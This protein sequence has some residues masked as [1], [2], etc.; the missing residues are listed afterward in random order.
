MSCRLLRRSAPLLVLAVVALGLLGARLVDPPAG[1]PGSARWTAGEAVGPVIVAQVTD[2]T[3][4]TAARAG[5]LVAV[6]AAA[7]GFV[8]RRAARPLAVVPAS[9]MRA[10]SEALTP[11][12]RRGPPAGRA[13]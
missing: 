9:G 3:R 5:A 6:A 2:R 10:R 12:R 4:L 7:A 1:A 11:L 8:A 13:R